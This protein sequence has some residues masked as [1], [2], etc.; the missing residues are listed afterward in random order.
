MLQSTWGLGLTHHLRRYDWSAREY[1]VGSRWFLLP[2]G[3]FLAQLAI[4]LIQLVTAD[5]RYYFT[6]FSGGISATLLVLG[7]L[8]ITWRKPLGSSYQFTNGYSSIY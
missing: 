6:D 8:L 3:C 4:S 7:G 5:R 1:S 2:I